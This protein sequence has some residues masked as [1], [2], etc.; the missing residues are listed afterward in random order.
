MGE[1]M[2][3]LQKPVDLRKMIL[4]TKVKANEKI[5]GKI[6]PEDIQKR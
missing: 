2:L 1:V 5:I 3:E 6:F 4:K